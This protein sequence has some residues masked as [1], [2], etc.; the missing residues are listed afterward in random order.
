M[1]TM[2]VVHWDKSVLSL[3]LKEIIEDHQRGDRTALL[4]L[5]AI[6]LGTVVL[7]ATAKLAKP[8]VKNIIKTG[9]SFSP[10]A[11]VNSSSRL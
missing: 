3:H 8:M 5:G 4:G 10:V 6:F 9:L 2:S 11:K 1:K 7:P